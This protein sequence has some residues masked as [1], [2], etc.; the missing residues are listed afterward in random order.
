MTL[1][2]DFVA[3][4]RLLRWGASR[5]P[6]ASARGSGYAGPIHAKNPAGRAKR[7]VEGNTIR[8]KCRG[9]DA[10]VDVPRLGGRRVVLDLQQKDFHVPTTGVGR[11]RSSL[12]GARAAFCRIGV[13]ET[14]AHRDAADRRAESAGSC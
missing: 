1:R 7:P 5:F 6:A 9:V 14:S 13:F 10:P 11:R 8:V 4:C 2:R 12:T 3:R